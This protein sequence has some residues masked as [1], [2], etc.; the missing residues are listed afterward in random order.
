MNYTE[1]RTLKIGFKTIID[2]NLEGVDYIDP[3][4]VKFICD[5]QAQIL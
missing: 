3:E 2:E 1:L 4:S 5:N